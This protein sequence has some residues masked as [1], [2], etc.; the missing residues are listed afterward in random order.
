VA[1]DEQINLKIEVDASQLIESMELAK[2]TDKVIEFVSEKA[3]KAMGKTITM[4]R[5]TW[6]ITQGVLQ[7]A[8]IGVSAQFRMIMSAV[9]GGVSM[10]IPLLTAQT[11]TPA[12]MLQGFLGLMELTAAIAAMG[13]AESEFRQN[14]AAYFAAMRI[15]NG[16]QALFGG[17]YFL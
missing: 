6:A 1:D 12:T 15:L 14:E 4:I 16:V 11:M 3:R 17:M 10:L 9:L 5:A 13:V 2:E 8:G 7:A